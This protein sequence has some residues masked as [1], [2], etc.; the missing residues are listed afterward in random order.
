MQTGKPCQIQMNAAVVQLNLGPEVEWRQR[1]AGLTQAFPT[2]RAVVACILDTF[3]IVKRKDEAK[4][5]GDHRTKRTLLEIYDPLTE[6]M[7][8][9]QIYRARLH[10]R[11]SDSRVA[12][13]PRPAN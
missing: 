11:P 7:Q 4:F 3:P 1:P 10:P 2:P 12:H 6:A 13:P 5:N 9:G 8:S